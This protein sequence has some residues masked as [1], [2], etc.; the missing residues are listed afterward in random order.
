MP[1]IF[2]LLLIFFGAGIAA[3]AR[4]PHYDLQKDKHWLDSLDRVIHSINR[5]EMYDVQPL[6]K[7][8]INTN[9]LAGNYYEKMFEQQQ[10]PDLKKAVLYYSKVGDLGT[11]PGREDYFSLMAI[12][13]NVCR[14]LSNYYFFGKGIKANREKALEYAISGAGTNPE[15]FK[16]YSN[17]F[18]NCECV[19]LGSTKK[20]DSMYVLKLNPFIF[21]N[22]QNISAYE[23]SLEAIRKDFLQAKYE[24]LYLHI[25]VIGPS[26]MSGYENAEDIASKFNEYFVAKKTI[27]QDRVVFYGDADIMHT[28]TVQI[29][30]RNTN[31]PVNF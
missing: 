25:R 24:E 30:F 27:G 6:M 3:A 21:K 5:D 9:I 2:L 29:S 17:R 7:K 19:V 23:K 13:N 22:P 16:L 8:Y 26:N 10:L 12:R 18:F 15:L 31:Q 28:Y 20:N 1:R 14:K 4:Q 11:F